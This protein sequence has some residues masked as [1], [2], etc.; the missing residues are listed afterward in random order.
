MFLLYIHVVYA[1]SSNYSNDLY[2]DGPI[3]YCKC[4]TILNNN[5]I[6]VQTLTECVVIKVQ[7]SRTLHFLEPLCS[8][9]IDRGHN[10]V[11][12]FVLFI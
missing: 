3:F 6:T 1:Y 10:S 11:L 8:A 5:D 4:I 9:L 7:T 2:K 12:S